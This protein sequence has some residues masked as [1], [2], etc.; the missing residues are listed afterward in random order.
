MATI[1]LE[2]EAEL[3]RIYKRV[4]QTIDMKK[5]KRKGQ[6]KAQVDKYRQEKE[7]SNEGYSRGGW[8]KKINDAI[9]RTLQ[10]KR[11]ERVEEFKAKSVKKKAQVVIGN[12]KN[13]IISAVYNKH[14]RKSYVV[15][16][17]TKTGRFTKYSK[18]EL[19]EVL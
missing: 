19:I 8:G 15:A 13:K 17:N 16:R 14:I 2:D 10:G 11:E 12:I 7:L 9:F 3:D 6:L 18:S 4:E 1:D 5:V